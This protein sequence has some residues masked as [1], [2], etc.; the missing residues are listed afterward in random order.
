M[1]QTPIKFVTFMHAKD[2][3]PVPAELTWEE[4]VARLST[5]AE[6]PHKD[7]PA[8]SPC[9]YSTLQRGNKNVEEV[10]AVVLDLDH[11]SHKESKWVKETMAQVGLNA[12]LHTTFSHVPPQD[13]CYRLIIQLTQPVKRDDWAT[14]RQALITHLSLPCDPATKDPARIYYWPATNTPENKEVLVF[15]GEPLDVPSFLK[16]REKESTVSAVL[17]MTE[18]KKHLSNVT[19]P[20]NRALIRRVINGEPLARKGER[21]ATMF[22]LA[23]VMVYKCPNVD[24]EALV[25]IARTSIDR[26][27]SDQGLEAELDKFREKL[28]RAKEGYLESKAE[29]EKLRE[30]LIKAQIMEASNG[31]TDQTYAPTEFEKYAQEHGCTP[32]AFLRRLIIQCGTAYYVFSNGR[33]MSPISHQELAVSLKRDLAQAPI[34]WTKQTA[35]GSVRKTVSDLLDDYCT[36]A[37]EVKADMTMQRSSYDP[38]TQTFYEAACPIRPF[39]AKYHQDVHDWL[40]KLGGPEAHKLLD[41]VASVTVLERQAAALFLEGDAGAGKGLLA[42]GLA[43]LWHEGGPT[44]FRALIS[45]FN[46]QVAKCPLI[47]ADEGFPKKRD[48]SVNDELR[49]WLGSSELLLTRKYMPDAPLKGAIRLMMASNNPRILDSIEELSEDDRQALAVRLLYIK[50][51]KDAR[52]YLEAMPIE[53]RQKFADYK[54][55]QHALWLRAERVVVP[56]ARFIV[57]G[58]DSAIHTRL[59]VSNGVAGSVCEFLCKQILDATPTMQNQLKDRLRWGN[60]E[61]W[62]SAALFQDKAQ[63]ETYVPGTYFPSSA[64]LY[65]GLHNLRSKKVKLSKLTKGV[66]WGFSVIRLELLKTWINMNADLDV[67]MLIEKVN[68]ERNMFDD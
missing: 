63:W 47:F 4:L 35:K 8:W 34:E 60:G 22:K 43:H 36:V 57:E 61:V 53:E 54:I 21:D 49:Q 40:V 62:V 31:Q 37:R 58:N 59:M 44:P 3:V 51:N 5:Y 20:N 26:M 64:S 32:Q 15:T 18:I 42:S 65:R 17:D 67:D 14:L 33:Y 27:D 1:T 2:N 11:L 28:A 46:S 50:V 16:Q 29:E 39:E 56:G 13:N 38:S 45:G 12:V 9:V 52:Q 48:Y 19:N 30:G 25:E 68:A 7:G 41:W 66:K 23:S 55:P 10:T 24:L 6:R